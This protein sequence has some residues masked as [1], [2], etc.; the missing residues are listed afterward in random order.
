MNK[1]SP[2]KEEELLRYLDGELETSLKIKLEAELQGP[3]LKERLEELRTI[4]SF[5][6]RKATFETP[7]KTFTQ[8]VMTGLDAQP[9]KSLFSPRKGLLLLMGVI[10]ASVLALMLLSNG[11]FD[12]TSSLLVDTTPIKNKWI[13]E[14]TFTIPFNGKILVNGIIFLNLALALVLLD[15]TVLRPLFQKRAS[16][17]SIAKR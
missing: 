1:L 4:R 13:E 12:Q 15:R 11:V 9:V 16:V 2:A 7:S 3:D 10:I 5:L 8:K 6:V 14:T 17:L